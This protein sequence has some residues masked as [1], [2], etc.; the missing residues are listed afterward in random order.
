MRRDSITP[1]AIALAAMHAACA[2]K[3]AAQSG[4]VPPPASAEVPT[5]SPSTATVS[6]ASLP[7]PAA[8]AAPTAK[9]SDKLWCQCGV[10]DFE[11]DGP[12]DGRCDLEIDESGSA[13]LT[14][15]RANPRFTARL[16][17]IPRKPGEQVDYA[18]HGVFDFH[19]QEAW[20]GRQHLSVLAVAEHDYRVTVARSDDGP[21]SHVLWVTCFR[22]VPAVRG[23]K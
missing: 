18:F 19:C 5:E 11:S 10:I 1:M 14:G 16:E 3:P 2:S 13:K 20:C 17:P 4:P 21:P 12:P 22:A 23:K 9:P 15:R 8:S 7:A 6:V